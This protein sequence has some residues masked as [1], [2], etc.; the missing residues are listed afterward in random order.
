MVS[1]VVDG[2]LSDA[3]LPADAIDA[4]VVA[5]AAAEGFCGI[6]NVSVWTTTQAGLSGVPCTRVDTGPSSG[7]AALWT[8]RGLVGAGYAETVL[9]VGWE[10]MTS[11]PTQEATE[12]LGRLMARDEQV[13]DL[14]LPG[15]VALLASAYLDRY[16]L[17]PEDLAPV[18]VKAHT[19]ASSNPIAQFRTPVTLDDVRSS[20]LIAD[21]LRLLHCAPLTDGAAA[22]VVS[23]RGPVR[24]EAMGHATD[25]LG[26][27]QRRGPVERF[28]ATREAAEGMWSGTSYRAGDVDVA[29]VHDAFSVLEPVN[30]EDLGFA[31]NGQGLSLV[32][33]PDEDPLAGDLVVNPSGGLKARGHPVGAT[34]VAQLAELYDQLTGRAA[35]PVDG[36][37]L[38]V[39][40]N[41]GGFGNNVHCALLEGV[42]S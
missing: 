30:L 41:I 40:H 3:S 32:P 38:A 12:I 17:T 6:G 23:R 33:A 25:A 22:V 2:A 1:E 27:T 42:S 8:A 29:E 13:L 26:I 18:P 34:G 9:V 28:Q 5:N 36:A 21:P 19:L 14:S 4:L 24:I 37:E 16:D 10:A 11:V 31:E 7:L 20:R 39:A 35:N 15:L